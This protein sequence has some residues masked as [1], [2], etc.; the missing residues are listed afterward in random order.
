MRTMADMSFVGEISPRVKSNLELK[1]NKKGWRFLCNT[2][3]KR[4]INGAYE[5]WWNNGR[6]GPRSEPSYLDRNSPATDEQLRREWLAWDSHVKDIKIVDEA[7]DWHG[8]ALRQMKAV[9]SK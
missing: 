8:N 4:V 3:P 9:Y 2:N 5:E 7:Y 6:I 1:L